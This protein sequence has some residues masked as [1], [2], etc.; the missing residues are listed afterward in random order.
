MGHSFTKFAVL[1]GT[2][3][4]EKREL[5]GDVGAPRK[6]AVIGQVL[7]ETDSES[8]RFG[9]IRLFGECFQGQYL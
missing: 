6:G 2:G 3:C 4:E 7:W 5:H 9:C 8:L 1:G